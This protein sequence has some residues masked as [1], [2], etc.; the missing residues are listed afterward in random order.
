MTVQWATAISARQHPVTSHDLR[1]IESSEDE[2]VDANWTVKIDVPSDRQGYTIVGLTNWVQYDVQVR[3]WNAGGPGLWSETETGTPSNTSARV[4]LQWDDTSVDVDEDG[5]SVTLTAIATTDRDVALPSDFFFRATVETSD[6][7]ATVSSDYLPPPSTTLTFSNTDFSRMQ[8]G[9]L[10]RYR[11]SMNFN[12]AIVNDAV[13]ESDETFTATL[14]LANPDIGNLSLSNS[15]ATV[16]INDD[17]HVPVVLGWLNDTVSIGEGSSTVALNATATTTVNK[18]PEP[19]FSFQATVATAAGTATQGDDYTQVSTTVTFRHTDSWSA[20]GSGADRRYRATK[21][22][23]VPILNDTD[24]ERNETFTASLSYVGSARH[25]TGSPAT[26]TVTIED[27]DLPPVSIEADT[28]TAAEDGALQFTLTRD[29]VTDDALT[30]NVRVSETGRML[31]S[32]Q[33]T[34][35][36]FNANAGTTTLDVALADDTEDEDNSVVTV[37][38]VSGSNYAVGSPSSATATGL[39]NDHV[40]VTLSWNRTAVSVAERAGTVSL[41]AVATTTR[42]KQPETGFSFV[43]QATYADGTA[44]SN[45][46]TPGSTSMTFRQSDF[47][48]SGSRYR[49]TKD[50]TVSITSTDGDEAANETFTATLNYADPMPYLTGS[51]STA[52]VTI[53]DNDDP[54]VTITADQ[55]SVAETAANITFTL[56]RDGDAASSLR[57]AVDVAETGGNML[58][59]AGRYN[60]NF[61]TGSNDATLTVNLRDDTEDEDNSTVTAEVVNGSGYFPGSPGSAETTV[62]DDDH[63]PVTLAWEETTLTVGEGD[64]TAS[65]TAVATTTKDKAP[66]SG[67]D[68]DATVTV[69]DGS[70]SDPDDYTPSSGTTLSFDD[71][72]FSLTTINGQ[73]RYQATLT[74]FLSIVGDDTHERDENFSARLAWATPRGPHLRGGNSTARVT[75]TDDDPVPLTLGWEQ[76]EWSVEESDGSVTLKAVALTSINKQPEDG[77]S[78]DARVATSSGSASSGSDFTALSATET[79]LRSDFSRVTFDGRSRYRA[80]KEFTV[81]IESDNVPESNENLTV[82]LDFVGSTHA[83]LTTG[84]ADATVWIIEDDA[85]TA[86]VQL[87]RNS[88]PGGVSQGSTLTYRYTV[89]N[90][91]PATATG[92]Q[93]VIHL[94]PN[95]SVVTPLPSG[96]SH[97]DGVVTCSLG[98]LDDGD[99]EEITIEATVQSVPPDGIVN[100]AYVESSQADPTP[101]N[102]TYPATS[103]GAV[104]AVAAAAAAAVAA[105]A[106]A[107]AVVAAAVAAVAAAVVAAAAVAAEVSSARLPAPRSARATPPRAPWPRTPLPAGTSAIPSPPPDRA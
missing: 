21:R 1:Y 100:R 29:G 77:F 7:G 19:G 10:Q 80:E 85:A 56:T 96:C 9:G 73:S 72:D 55:S 97:S 94:D 79:F 24:D 46:Y 25:L 53:V 98:S 27:N 106:V 62:T 26:A 37:R 71:G 32:G 52:T 3:G 4:T 83:N 74:F 93:L 101:G 42:N 2:T 76:P 48:L 81:T 86:D 84:V 107:A 34:T 13:D 15:T 58:A 40:P 39:D 54:L 18:R 45:D 87:T 66:E 90:N 8:V 28:A 99:D 68:F 16:T 61:A 75:I 91:G 60:V 50:F 12:V 51:A 47:A 6:G 65:L 88:S 30:V 70:A 22:I 92:L 11:A 41:Q 102:N 5:G 59:R 103:S 23:T 105:A 82:S 95:L 43:A 14:A 63:V 49:A 33:P 17:E 57:A 69:S 64:G 78:F 67:F 44:D 36:T 35:A 20:V 31:A 38:V 104:A 89:R